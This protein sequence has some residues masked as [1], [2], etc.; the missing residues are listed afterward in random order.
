[1]F[2]N[3]ILQKKDIIGGKLTSWDRKVCDLSA[4]N[5][6]IYYKYRAGGYKYMI[7]VEN[8]DGAF[9]EEGINGKSYASE[10][11]LKTCKWYDRILI[12]KYLYNHIATM[13][14]MPKQNESNNSYY[15][16]DARTK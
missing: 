12:D 11:A 2:L 3:G 14:G 6:I 5:Y 13:K 8:K 4:T 10:H 7:L 1:M 9:T 16:R 15:K